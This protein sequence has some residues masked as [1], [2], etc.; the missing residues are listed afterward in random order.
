MLRA[1][2]EAAEAEDHYR[3]ACASSP[4]NAAARQGDLYE[5]AAVRPTVANRMDRLSKSIPLLSGAAIGIHALEDLS[6]CPPPFAKI[7]VRVSYAQRLYMKLIIFTS[8][9]RRRPGIHFAEARDGRQYL[10][11]RYQRL[12]KHHAASTPIR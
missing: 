2:L 10:I 5:P 12:F 3:E 8:G 7:G 1:K 6:A 9:K 11:W 4:A